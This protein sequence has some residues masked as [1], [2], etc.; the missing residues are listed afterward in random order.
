MGKN[1]IYIH[2]SASNQPSS[3]SR[4]S[5]P[6]IESKEGT[7][8]RYRQKEER[9]RLLPH[10]LHRFVNRFP[11]GMLT[12]TVLL[13]LGALLSGSSAMAS[14]SFYTLALGLIFGVIAAFFGIAD[15]MA[16]SDNTGV[17][18]IGMGHGFLAIIALALFAYSFFIRYLD[19]ANPSNS[20]YALSFAGF[21]A[22]IWTTVKGHQMVSKYAVGIDPNA[23]RR[24]LEMRQHNELRNVRD[25]AH[26]ELTTDAEPDKRQA[27]TK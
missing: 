19:P 7:E 24:S 5:S 9:R 25:A 12:A 16:S 27:F 21:A 3:I 10:G 1:I 2:K 26:R 4:R 20:A 14:A 13:D 8:T 18:T 15:W 22:L 11:I 6:V 23:W 17:K